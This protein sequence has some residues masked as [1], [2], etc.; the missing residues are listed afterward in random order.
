LG[1]EVVIFR[2]ESFYLLWYCPCDAH[3]HLPRLHRL[4]KKL[5]STV[6]PIP[7]FEAQLLACAEDL[8]LVNNYHTST[9]YENGHYHMLRNYELTNN[10]IGLHLF[11]FIQPK[12][13]CH[14][15]A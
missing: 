7:Y 6:N 8:G 13:L 1:K 15:M 3:L 4:K 2:L 12:L 9:A 5:L 10:T 11:K 14:F